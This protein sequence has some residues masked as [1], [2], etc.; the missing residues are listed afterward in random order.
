MIVKF[1][2]NVFIAADPIRQK[3]KRI[4]IEVFEDRFLWDSD[5][6]YEICMDDDF[7]ENFYVSLFS[8]YERKVFDEK[9]S[10]IIQY[11]AYITPQH[12]KYLTSITVG[13]D[14]GEVSP[15]LA[16]EVMTNPSRLVV[17]NATNDWKLILSF[18]DKYTRAGNRRFVYKLIQKSIDQHWLVPE[19][20]GGKGQIRN[21]IQDLSNGAY[22]NISHLKIATVFD[23]DRE[24]STVLNHE[25]QLIIQYLKDDEIEGANGAKYEDSDKLIWHMLFKRELEN[26]V[27]FNIWRHEVDLTEEQIHHLEDLHGSD[28]DFIDFSEYLG[29]NNV[30]VKRR[31]PDFVASNFSRLEFETR[32]DHHRVPLELPNGTVEQVTEVEQVLVKLA[33]II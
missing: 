17:E 2:P 7:R 22:Q 18:V 10:L 1:N 11:A 12:E 23:S 30:D 24:S 14:A 5:N 8:E 28:Y 31:F 4:L 3:V 21:R 16:F 33:K 26:Y 19:N 13:V 29:E 9:V 15:D 27:P 6:L 20:A 25:V 32:C